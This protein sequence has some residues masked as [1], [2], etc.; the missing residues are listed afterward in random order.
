MPVPVDIN[1]DIIIV[2]NHIK[3]INNFN[4]IVLQKFTSRQSY[5]I[6]KGHYIPI[7]LENVSD[8]TSNDLENRRFY[9]QTYNLTLQ[10]YLLDSDEFE[11]KPTLNKFLLTTEISTSPNKPKKINLYDDEIFS[12]NINGQNNQTTVNI[13]ETIG[14]LHSVTKN[15]IT[16]TKDIDFYH[17]SY[18]SKITLVTPLTT[19]DKITIIYFKSKKNS[20]FKKDEN[21]LTTS[22]ELQ[23]Y[24]GI[25]NYITLNND[26]YKILSLTNGENLI[27]DV[28]YTISDLRKI[29]F[30]NEPEI[31]TN[32][33]ITYQH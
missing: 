3:D 16:L 29:T 32:I 13:G 27:E 8:N 30:I 26:I 2:C 11:V 28:D 10:G 21:S 31:G 15:G 4:K 33:I 7:I 14:Q 19:D 1:Y 18:T 20:I 17:V 23:T 5:T 24:N 9:V 6:I 25:V 12:I 22:V